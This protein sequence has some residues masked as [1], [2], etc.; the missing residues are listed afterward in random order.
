MP[1][2]AAP[3]LLYLETKWA[4]LAPHAKVASLLKDVLPVSPTT[5]VATIR[6]H[7][8]RVAERDEEA[9]DEE[10][11]DEEALDEE[12]VF[13]AEGCPRDWAELPRPEGRSPPALTEDMCATGKTRRIT[14]R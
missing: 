1:E 11:L 10:A 5:N 6:N 9:L 7:L 14:S 12:R 4:S 3:E 8:Q 2:H 13:F